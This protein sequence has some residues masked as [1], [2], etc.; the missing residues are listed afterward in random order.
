[1]ATFILTSPHLHLLRSVLCSG[2]PS[3]APSKPS[4]TRWL[5]KRKSFICSCTRAGARETTTPRTPRRRRRRNVTSYSSSISSRRRCLMLLP[6]CRRRSK[7]KTTQVNAVSEAI[8]ITFAV[9]YV[10]CLKL[11]GRRVLQRNRP[12]VYDCWCTRAKQGH[13]HACNHRFIVSVRQQPG[14][15]YLQK[16]QNKHLLQ[17]TNYKTNHQISIQSVDVSKTSIYTAYRHLTS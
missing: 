5:A 9:G 2:M 6:V 7:S 1:M 13:S 3:G 10:V 12:C 14:I 11:L 15:K 4:T 8:V 16:K 17:I